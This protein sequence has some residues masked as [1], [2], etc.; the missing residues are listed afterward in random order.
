MRCKR[1]HRAC[2]CVYVWTV[3]CMNRWDTV[4]ASLQ[5][6]GHLCGTSSI[7]AANLPTCQPVPG[8][9]GP[10]FPIAVPGK[11]RRLFSGLLMSGSSSRGASTKPELKIS[12][13]GLSA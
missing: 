13:W 7:A 12:R 6:I 9:E 4:H 5:G 3:I 10:V 11:R 8:L 1:N 2:K